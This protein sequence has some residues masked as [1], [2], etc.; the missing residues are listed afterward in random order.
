MSFF[1]EKTEVFPAGQKIK[2]SGR[3][4]AQR[5]ALPFGTECGNFLLL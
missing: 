2:K 3:F 4:S 5:E 1:P